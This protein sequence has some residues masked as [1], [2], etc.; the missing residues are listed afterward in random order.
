MVVI[1]R[2]TLVRGEALGAR[3]VL[4]EGQR[5]LGLALEALAHKRVQGGQAV[6]Q[7]RGVLGLQRVAGQAGV[8]EG[9]QLVRLAAQL[10]VLLGG[11]DD[12]G[13]VDAAEALE[14]LDLLGDAIELGQHLL[15]QLLALLLAERGLGLLVGRL[16]LLDGVREEPIAGCAVNIFCLE[17]NGQWLELL[18]AGGGAVAQL[19]RD[20][21]D[22][23]VHLLELHV[24]QFVDKGAL[25]LGGPAVVVLV[26]LEQLLQLV[27]VNVLRLP[28]RV[29]APAQRRAELHRGRAVAVAGCRAAVCEELVAEMSNRTV[30][31]SKSC[32]SGRA[33]VLLRPRGRKQACLCCASGELPL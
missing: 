14:L 25:V 28:R 1:A 12:G 26:V 3:L 30:S 29:H 4:G 7:R 15:Q 2:R 20:V 13:E 27:V 32:R 22:E 33:K 21:E 9:P 16:A 23:A 17:A 31:T 5:L 11:L 10:V 18:L 8:D 24:G 6:Q 19:L